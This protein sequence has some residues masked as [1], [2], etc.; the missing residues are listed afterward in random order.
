MMEI[1]DLRD[2]ERGELLK[3][4]KEARLE[5]VRLKM[6]RKTGS[7]ADGSTIHK[8]QKEIA[9]SVIAFPCGVFSHETQLHFSGGNRINSMISDKG[10]SVIQCVALDHVIPG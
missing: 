10:E 4:L 9:Q 8:K 6:E 5:L 2:K 7:L 1:K 3:L